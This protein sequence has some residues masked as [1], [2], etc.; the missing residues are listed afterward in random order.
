M[1]PA[2]IITDER[3]EA[4]SD[5][6][7]AFVQEGPKCG[8]DHGLSFEDINLSDNSDL[9]D[10]DLLAQGR[11]FTLR[12]YFPVLL[13]QFVMMMYA[14]ASR[15]GRVV[16]Y[17]TGESLTAAQS[18]PRYL[19][20]LIRVMKWLEGDDLLVGENNNTA[21][22]KDLNVLRKMHKIAAKSY[23]KRP[24]PQL[25]PLTELQSQV[26]EA[27]RREREYVDLSVAP[28]WLL[29]D[30]PDIP[31]SQLPMSAGQWRFMGLIVL[32]LVGSRFQKHFG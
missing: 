29:R 10:P 15:Y 11:E 13:V 12:N 18:G 6:Y 32:I 20:S 27:I 1:A 7:Q 16:L 2:T 26:L 23:F 24:K 22:P 14:M 9:H 3:H 5:F 17:H 8:G 28:D 21:G 31:L 30:V 19:S 25:P 4:N